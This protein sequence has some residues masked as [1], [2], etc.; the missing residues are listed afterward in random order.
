MMLHMKCMK[1]LAYHHNRGDFD[2]SEAY[3]DF[4]DDILERM[5]EMRGL[6]YKRSDEALIDLKTGRENHG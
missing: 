1:Q 3:A 5:A 4:G 6:V 2:K